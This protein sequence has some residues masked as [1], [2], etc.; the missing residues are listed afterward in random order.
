M[1]K[2]KLNKRIIIIFL[3]DF[4]LLIFGLLYPSLIDKA[5]VTDKVTTY[6]ENLLNSKYLLNSLIKTNITN[7]LF[8]NTSIFIFTFLIFTFPI[9]IIIY[10]IKV[11]SL[12]LTISSII[13]IY[14]LKG[15]IYTLII[16]FP[17]IFS[18][19]TMTIYFYYSL[20]YFLI[21]IKY[22][23]KNLTKRL[24]KSYLKIFL[25][26]LIIQ[27]ILAIFDSYLSFYLFKLF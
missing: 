19:I 6:I 11:F 26:T 25:I 14:K 2:E 21:I 20:S 7:A 18:L 15:I 17:I 23:K 4:L 27:V 9:T 8:E 16:I 5:I 12:G 13:Y 1:L 10:F 24:L 3:I 22:H